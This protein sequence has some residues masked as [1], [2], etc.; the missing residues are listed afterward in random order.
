MAESISKIGYVVIDIV[1]LGIIEFVCNGG[2]K[3]KSG[4]NRLVGRALSYWSKDHGS[5]SKCH[6]PLGDD[7]IKNVFYQIV[8]YISN[9]ADCEQIMFQYMKAQ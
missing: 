7:H 4:S 2:K 8:P 6:L 3:N 1:L 9:I 5:E